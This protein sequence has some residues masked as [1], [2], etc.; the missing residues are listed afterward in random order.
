L[1]RCMSLHVAHSYGADL[2]NFS[3]CNRSKADSPLRVRPGHFGRCAGSG[4]GDRRFERG[5]GGGE[6]GQNWMVG[7]AGDPASLWVRSCDPRCRALGDVLLR[8]RREC[9]KGRGR[10]NVARAMSVL[11]RRTMRAPLPFHKR[12]SL[13]FDC[14]AEPG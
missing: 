11:A 9:G 12:G 10:W 8:C 6:K 3:V 13:S 7:A 5:D 2:V 4:S 14:P 1:L